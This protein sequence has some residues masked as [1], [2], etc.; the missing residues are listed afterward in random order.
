MS[1]NTSLKNVLERADL[2]GLAARRARSSDR[3]SIPLSQLDAHLGLDWKLVLKRK[4]TATVERP[5]KHDVLLEDRVWILLWRM[6]FPTMSGPGG[7][8]VTANPDA[9]HSIANQLDAVAL[10]DEVCVAVE[11]KSSINRGKRPNMQEELAKLAVVRGPLAMAV[12]P[13]GQGTKRTPI[14]VFWTRNAVLSR[15][16]RERAKQHTIALLSD[17]DLTYYE[18]L[19]GHLG[20][21]ARYQ[22]LA[23][24]VPGKPIPN[25]ARTVPA[26]QS[27]MAGYTAYTFAIDPDFLL[28]VAYVSHRARG[29][30]SDIKT[31]Q[32]M[33]SKSRL[34]K[35]AEYIKSD[36]DAMFPTNIVINLEKPEKGKK[37]AS[38]RFERAKQAEGSNGAVFGWL[39]LNPA[40][41]SAWII[42]G[43]HRLFAYSY[44]GEPYASK[45]KLAVLA[46]EGLPGSVQQ[47]LFIDINAEQKSVKRG[48]LQELFADLHRGSDNPRDRVKALISESVQELDSDPDSPLFDRIL[49]ADS[50]RTETRCITLTSVFSALD[51]PGFFYGSVKGNVVM[52]A[53]P[54]WGTSDD[55]II[56]RTTS[57]LNGWLTV[58]RD[59]VPDW[60]DLGSAEGGGL[61]MNDGVGVCISVLRSVVEHL[62][63]GK[64]KLWSLDPKEANERLAPYAEAFADYL[65]EMSAEQRLE[66]RSAR[67]NQG[68]AAGL[69]HAQKYLQSHFADFDPDGLAEFIEREQ[70]KT[71][72]Q[73]SSLIKS[74]ERTLQKIVIGVL[75]AQYGPDGDH[76]WYEAIPVTVRKPASLRQD[77]DKNQRGARERYL[78]LI[79]YR[80]IITSTQNWTLF[81]ALLGRGKGNESKDKRT[82][83]IARIN[84]V[85]HVAEHASSATWVSFETLGELTEVLEWIT[86][87]VSSV[88]TSVDFLA[89]TAASE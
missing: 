58:V 68:Q 43:Q 38:L 42:D 53:G 15:T 50:G 9:E 87:R 11:C 41:K 14:L 52:D 33:L 32:R 6:G 73:A 84:D 2:V 37:G 18:T 60:W 40:Y 27:K 76:W 61:A 20:A 23:D 30:A 16:D 45:A 51:K 46:F 1:S 89:E 57:I 35:I 72:D 71:N 59:R 82:E 5:K 81:A 28:K 12:N 34:R 24:L 48:L 19:V 83:W 31:Y 88:G 4:T 79:D 25:L 10:D 75:K 22:F 26:L 62:D 56:R 3:L 78:D 65:G 55:S 74:I 70:A 86:T 13:P 66:F 49:L 21:A 17:D 36:P 85:R 8:V 44:A 47:K 54:M 67:G 39:T 64:L 69:R 80:T 29:R 63:T 7:A 77:E